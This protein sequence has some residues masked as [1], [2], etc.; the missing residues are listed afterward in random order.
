MTH[1]NAEAGGCACGNA[2]TLSPDERARVL[3]VRGAG[4][5]IM[6]CRSIDTPERLALYLIRQGAERVCTRTLT[7]TPADGRVA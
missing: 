3:A 6:I 2:C 1:N 4:E 7:L 5:E